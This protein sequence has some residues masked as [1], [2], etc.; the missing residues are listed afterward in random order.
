VWLGDLSD[1]QGQFEKDQGVPLRIERERGKETTEALSRSTDSS[2]LALRSEKRKKGQTLGEG[3]RRDLRR[4]AH[5]KTRLGNGKGVS[6]GEKKTAKRAM[7]RRK[8]EIATV[9]LWTTR[10]DVITARI[11][12]GR[13][14]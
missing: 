7:G 2:H 3:T 14:A 13:E 9:L 1:K 4:D 10:L 5:P 8:A 12:R 11:R 6:A